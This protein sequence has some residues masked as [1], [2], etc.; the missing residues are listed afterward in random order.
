MWRFTRGNFPVRVRDP[1][2]LDSPEPTLA[3]AV[4]GNLSGGYMLYGPYADFEQAADAIEGLDGWV[5]RL[6]P[7]SLLAS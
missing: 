5:M 7:A 3:V 6:H 4:V 2:E 1:E